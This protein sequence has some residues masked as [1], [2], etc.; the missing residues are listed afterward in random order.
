MKVEWCSRKRSLKAAHHSGYDMTDQRTIHSLPGL[1]GQATKGGRLRVASCFQILMLLAG[2]WNVLGQSNG[3]QASGAL[4]NTATELQFDIFPG[5]G[6]VVKRQSWIPL[7]FEIYH[8][9]EG[10]SGIIQINKAGGQVQHTLPV[11]LPKGTRKRIQIPL[12]HEGNSFTWDIRLYHESGDLLAERSQFQNVEISPHGFVLGSVSESFAGQPE[13]PDQAA[14]EDRA[15]MPKVGRLMAENLPHHAIAYEGLDALYLHAS[16]STKLESSQWQALR[17]WIHLGGYLI[18]CAE[19]PTQIQQSPQWADLIPFQPTGIATLPW[20]GALEQWLKSTSPQSAPRSTCDPAKVQNKDMAQRIDAL[21]DNRYLRTQQDAFRQDQV[22]PILTGNIIDGTPWIVQDGLPLV[23]YARRGL[24]QIAFLTFNPEREPIKGWL[25]RPWFWAKL[26]GIPGE[27]FEMTRPR[28][29]GG[30]LLD[31]IAGSL[32]ESRQIQKLPVGWLMLMLTTYLIIIGPLDRW[33]LQK[34]HRE[35]WTWVTFPAYV[36]FFSIL[37]YYVGF[38]LR[39][40]QLEYRELHLEDWVQTSKN[41]SAV[42]H[43]QFGSIYSPSTSAYPFGGK[44]RPTFLRPEARAIWQGTVGGARTELKYE[45]ENTQASLQT[46]VW[47][48]R[49]IIGEGHAEQGA[50]PLKSEMRM[51]KDGSYRLQIE[52]QGNLYFEGLRLVYRDRYHDLTKGLRPGEALEEVI[53]PESGTRLASFLVDS[54]EKFKKALSSRSSALGE[55]YRLDGTLETVTAM[56]LI[57]K[58]NEH[59]PEYQS[60]IASDSMDWTPYLNDQAPILL[61]WIG[62]ESTSEGLH[63]FQTKAFQKDT[64]LR[65]LLPMPEPNVLTP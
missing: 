64:V 60:L 32:I 20:S 34:I 43:H 19:D 23:V 14:F 33:F 42:R 49:L 5:Y 46:P 55:T 15:F 10:F 25:N 57:Q 63:Q 8:E 6:D 28:E 65:M 11:E 29:V 62:Q 2:C 31:G 1:A 3:F 7:T 59:M 52:N 47:T 22:L 18:L 9:M 24:G 35:M 39:S 12:F 21:R 27:W 17:S 4:P 41:A 40:G 53:A 37:I 45:N 50:P 13:L 30:Q 16:Q 51:E 44:Q 56:T 36:L 54:A 26:S 61:G 38:R 48:S 58:I